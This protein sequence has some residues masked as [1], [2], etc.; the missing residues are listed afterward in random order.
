MS[1]STDIYYTEI[2]CRL[3][4]RDRESTR[5]DQLAVGRLVGRLNEGLICSSAQAE[6]TQRP[7]LELPVTTVLCVVQRTSW[8][9]YKTYSIVRDVRVRVRGLK[10]SARC[11]S[12]A[13]LGIERAKVTG[14]IQSDG[15]FKSTKRAR[16]RRTNT[17]WGFFARL[18][19]PSS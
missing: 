1:P 8:N 19:R 4:P 10:K 7:K 3:D 14:R 17:G 6:R 16:K 13:E 15:S 2:K 12:R 9:E 11:P 18:R 5:I